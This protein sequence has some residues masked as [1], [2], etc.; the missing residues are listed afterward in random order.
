MSGSG[1]SRPS[2]SS[3]QHQPQPPSDPALSN[4]STA[5]E[6]NEELPANEQ[7]RLTRESE[8]AA[9][10]GAAQALS[11]AQAA[12][13]EAQAREKHENDAAD[14]NAAGGGQFD[15]GSEFAQYAPSNSQ[16]SARPVTQDH[17]IDR[18]FLTGL[19][20]TQGQQQYTQQQQQQYLSHSQHPTPSAPLQPSPSHPPAAAASDGRMS[21]EELIATV[22]QQM[23][24]FERSAQYLEAEKARQHLESLKKRFASKRR[25]ALDTLQNEDIRVFF[26][27]VSQ[28]QANFDATWS[29][30]SSEH[31]LR[32]ADLIDNLKWRHEEAQREL[33]ETLRRKR[34]P[35]F[36][37]ELLNMRKRQVALARSKNYVAAEQVKRRGDQLESLEIHRIREQ[38][39]EENQLRF[40]ALL[41]KQVSGKKHTSAQ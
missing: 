23:M 37:V 30:K 6:F 41:K 9:E 35:K 24:E 7:E 4:P 36:S 39:R 21:D 22:E 2:S 10:A 5:A 20:L 15:L 34:M 40:Q 12:S 13:A 11:D 28:H 32:A 29:T 18:T 25:D 3:L 17:P 27:M 14:A 1:R 16:Q 38:T 33:Y 8:A 19:D 26:T 31:A